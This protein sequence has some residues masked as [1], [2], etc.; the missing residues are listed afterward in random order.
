MS[1]MY[2]DCL[3]KM[4]YTTIFSRGGLCCLFGMCPARLVTVETKRELLGNY[5][6]FRSI[7]NVMCLRR[8]QVG[9]YSVYDFQTPV[10]RE[11]FCFARFNLEEVVSSVALS[12]CFN[13]TAF[14]PRYNPPFLVP[15]T[16]IILKHQSLK[17]THRISR[18][19]VWL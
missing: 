18:T 8:Y 3:W 14:C 4:R 10:S 16:I 6:I 7:N 15:H 11:R 2:K 17:L 12:L 13:E 9:N 5:G 19:R 1:T